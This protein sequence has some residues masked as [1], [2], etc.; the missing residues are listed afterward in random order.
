[1]RHYLYQQAMLQYSTQHYDLNVAYLD[2][3]KHYADQSHLGTYVQAQ[4]SNAFSHGLGIIE[5]F[6][7][8]GGHALVGYGMQ[9]GPNGTFDIDVYDPD[10]PFLLSENS[11]GAEHEARMQADQ[12]HVAARVDMGR[13]R[14]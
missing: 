6:T 7:R 8:N 9:T 11:D 1:M 12:V 4:V 14:A 13:S 10:D 2:G 3:L 5:I